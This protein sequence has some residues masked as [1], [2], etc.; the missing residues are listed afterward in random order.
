VQQAAYILI[1]ESHK[2]V[3]HLQIGRNLLGKI[4]PET[5]RQTI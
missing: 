5:I 2:K 3:V 1:D 4:L